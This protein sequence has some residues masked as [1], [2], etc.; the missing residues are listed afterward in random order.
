MV[1]PDSQNKFLGGLALSVA[2]L[3][4]FISF[5]LFEDKSIALAHQPRKE[6]KT[7]VTD[8]SSK[9]LST[10]ETN[11][12][13]NREPASI[14]NS[15]YTGLSTTMSTPRDILIAEAP[16]KKLLKK[17]SPL[18][19]F[20]LPCSSSSN[21]NSSSDSSSSSR[22]ALNS[23]KQIS[24]NTNSKIKKQPHEKEKMEVATNFLQL[25]GH[26]CNFLNH[27]LSKNQNVK[28]SNLTNGYQ[29]TFFP[30]GNLKY[31]TDLIQLESGENQ[32]QVEFTNAQGQKILSNIFVTSRR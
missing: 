21:S 13:Q 8:E 28:I 9:T 27:N 19:D 29:A 32:I 18:F 16:P 12:S 7:S 14:Q 22:S 1:A 4:L 5:S 17:Q 10:Q 30:N 26:S 3:G 24:K 31:K 11:E 15:V 2:I 6:Q 20:D 23:N 25:S